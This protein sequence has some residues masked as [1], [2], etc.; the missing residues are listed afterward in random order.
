MLIRVKDTERRELGSKRIL[1]TKSVVR[2]M[3]LGFYVLNLLPGSGE[4][5]SPFSSES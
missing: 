3:E 4:L 2:S 1:A 5:F